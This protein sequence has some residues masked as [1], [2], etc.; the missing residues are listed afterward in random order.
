[1]NIIMVWI[2]ANNVLPPTTPTFLVV[3]LNVDFCIHRYAEWTMLMLGESILSLLT[4]DV[5]AEN[6]VY[7]STF[8]C[9][10]LTVIFLQYLHFRSMPH[11]ADDHAMRRSKNRGM[12]WI[13]CKYAYSGALLALG[14]A[15]TLFVTSFSY[16]VL[17]DDEDDTTDSDHRVLA[18]GG[19]GTMSRHEFK[20]REQRAAHL[21]SIAMALS[22]FA[23]DGMSIMN[24]GFDNA[25]KR[26][27]CDKSHAYNIKGVVLVALRVGAI[28]FVATLSQWKTDPQVL[29]GIG[30]GVTIGQ[31]L[32]RKLGQKYLNKKLE[33]EGTDDSEEG[34]GGDDDVPGEDSDEGDIQQE[35]ERNP[36]MVNT[37]REE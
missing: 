1:V 29:A 4:V 36:Q 10:L 37:I 31:I 6:S 7:F 9:S 27:Y 13:A 22:F 15:F 2:L 21:F 11:R 30:L 19:V 26:A 24:V 28:V 20:N 25:R 23:L 18:G 35:S 17:V 3:P 5:P 33:D 32:L 16:E 14:A 34:G 8:Y 12:V